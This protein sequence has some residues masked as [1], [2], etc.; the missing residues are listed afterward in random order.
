MKLENFWRDFR[1]YSNTKVHENQSSGSRV[2]P[3]ERRDMTKL[4]DTSRNFSNVPKNNQEELYNEE[5]HTWGLCIN[6]NVGSLKRIPYAWFST[7]SNFFSCHFNWGEAAKATVIQYGPDEGQFYP[8]QLGQTIA[9]GLR[10]QQENYTFL[11]SLS[12]L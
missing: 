11:T 12:V 5:S 9:R 3:C 2:V 8:S 4:I 10:K 1:K 6:K 7:K